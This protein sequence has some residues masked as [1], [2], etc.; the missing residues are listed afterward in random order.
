MSYIPILSLIM[1]L[2]LLLVSL[3]AAAISTSPTTI[4][5]SSVFLSKSS[6]NDN[7]AYNHTLLCIHICYCTS[8]HKD[9][10]SIMIITVFGL[11]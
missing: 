10:H 1:V 8:I 6:A 7:S 11:Y 9:Q 2:L 5:R 3:V 4:A